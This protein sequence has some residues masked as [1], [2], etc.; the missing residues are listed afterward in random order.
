MRIERVRLK[1]VIPNTHHH[2]YGLQLQPLR[3]SHVYEGHVLYL[4]AMH[5]KESAE[6][7]FGYRSPRK[8]HGR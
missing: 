7:E 5:V 2:M 3:W 4:H 8:G 1:R 6:I